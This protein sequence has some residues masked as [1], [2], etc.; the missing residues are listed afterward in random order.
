[1]PP[2]RPPNPITSMADKTPLSEPTDTQ[3][4]FRLTPS[5][6]E[7]HVETTDQPEGSGCP[8]RQCQAPDS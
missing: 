5:G 2:P 1:M 3:S 7:S 8:S 4:G 6:A